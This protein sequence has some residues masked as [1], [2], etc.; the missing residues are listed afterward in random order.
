[1]TRRWHSFRRRLRKREFGS[2]TIETSF[3]VDKLARKWS[4]WDEIIRT[5]KVRLANENMEYYRIV[6]VRPCEASY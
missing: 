4:G 1:M 6:R 3:V 2:Y 5:I